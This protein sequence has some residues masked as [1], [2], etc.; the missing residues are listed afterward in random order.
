MYRRHPKL[1]TNFWALPCHSALLSQLACSFL[2]CTTFP[3]L[4]ATNLRVSHFSIQ[5]LG[6]S[7]SSLD[8]LTGAVA[9]LA[10]L[11]WSTLMIMTRCCLELKLT[12]QKNLDAFKYD[13]EVSVII[14][15]AWIE[16]WS[17]PDRERLRVTPDFFL[18]TILS[19]LFDNVIF[20]YLTSSNWRGRIRRIWSSRRKGDGSR[21]PVS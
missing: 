1:K 18:N 10:I 4:L 13:T 9:S 11:K 2:I 12:R 15:I 6:C 5:V 17:V 8:L 14:C 16:Y 3:N 7:G 21:C 19:V 20:R